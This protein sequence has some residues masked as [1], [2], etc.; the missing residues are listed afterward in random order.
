MYLFVF[1]TKEMVFKKLDQF[2][3][4]SGLFQMLRSDWLSYSK[5]L[6]IRYSPLVAKSTGLENQNNGG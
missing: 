2:S 6:A 1:M 5:Y 4:T 3:P